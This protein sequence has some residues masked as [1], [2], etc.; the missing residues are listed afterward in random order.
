MWLENVS[1]K[2]KIV[3][4]IFEVQEQSIPINATEARTDKSQKITQGSHH[5]FF[6]T[7]MGS[8]HKNNI[9]EGMIL[10]EEGFTGKFVEKM[11]LN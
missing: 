4:H 2:R 1:I 3:S 11:D 9:R 6:S 7:N 5:F 8:W 10:F